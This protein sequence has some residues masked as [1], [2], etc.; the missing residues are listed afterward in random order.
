[1]SSGSP[2]WHPFLPYTIYRVFQF[3]GRSSANLWGS[4]SQDRASPGEP[5]PVCQGQAVVQSRDSSRAGTQRLWPT[6]S[7]SWQEFRGKEW[8][9]FSEENKIQHSNISERQSYVEFE[10]S[11]SAQAL[12][13][14]KNGLFQ[15]P[16]IWAPSWFWTHNVQGNCLHPP[17][18]FSALLFF[19]DIYN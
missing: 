19:G 6:E 2:A 8:K 18:G 12:T 5:G 1:M 15:G 17:A 16:Q 11:S 9:F 14:W 4:G 7:Q 10:K 3:P 13:K